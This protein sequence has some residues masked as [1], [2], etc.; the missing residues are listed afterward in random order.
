[1]LLVVALKGF[2]LDKLPWYCIPA[3]NKVH[4]YKVFVLDDLLGHLVIIHYRMPALI[5]S[6]LR[7][8]KRWQGT[9]NAQTIRDIKSYSPGEETTRDYRASLP[10]DN[11]I[12]CR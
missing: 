12:Y 5:L 1:M 3:L 6:R 9:F 8:G 2:V 10:Q 11:T 7:L 4:V